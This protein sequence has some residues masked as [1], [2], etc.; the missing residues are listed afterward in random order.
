MFTPKLEAISA[1]RGLLYAYLDSDHEPWVAVLGSQQDAESPVRPYEA[2]VALSAL[3][4]SLALSVAELA[5]SDAHDVIE[6]H[7]A[8]ISCLLLDD[9]QN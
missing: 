7:T 1:V 9:N 3:A 2:F 4:A 6:R 8:A 5:D